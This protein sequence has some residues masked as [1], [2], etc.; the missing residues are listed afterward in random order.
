MRGTVSVR[1]LRPTPKAAT[2]GSSAANTC[3]ATT[4]I[5][6]AASRR[7]TAEGGFYY[8]FLS[9]ARKI[10][11]VYIGG[12]ALAGYETVNWGDKVLFDGSRLANRDAFIYGGAI[13]LEVEAYL[14]DRIAL[15]VNLRERCLWG[16]STGHFHTQ[17]GIGLK[18]IID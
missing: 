5:R 8:N 15:T 11:F 16:G 1:R 12:S 18:F 2:S 17:Y 13:S 4:P 6:R 7:F 10:F 14:A 9:D 3:N